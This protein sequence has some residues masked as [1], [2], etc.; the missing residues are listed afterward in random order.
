MALD[1]MDS[2]KHC[3]RRMKYRNC[4]NFGCQ[5]SV[6]VTPIGDIPRISEIEVDVVGVQEVR[7]DQG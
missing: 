5:W 7:W 1:L 2:L 6:F 3:A 4:L